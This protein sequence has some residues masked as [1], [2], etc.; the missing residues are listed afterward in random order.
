MLELAQSLV[1]NEDA[2][3]S[4]PE[5]KRPVFIYEW[6][7]FLNKV[8]VAAHKNDIREC[9]PKIVEQLLQQINYGPGPPIRTLIGKNLANLFSVGDTFPLFNTIN[10]CND[11]L[12]LKDDNMT[13]AKLATVV[14]IGALYERLGRL[15]GRSYEETVHLLLRTLKSTESQMRIEIMFTFEKIV[16]GLGSAGSTTQKEI[17]RAAKSSVCDRSMPVRSAAAM[18]LIALINQNNF[19]YTTDLDNN[20]LLGFRALDGSNYDVRCSVAKYLAALLA[21]SQ[22]PPLSNMNQSS[23]KAN[24]NTNSIRRAKTEDIL[25]YLAGG[26]LRGGVGFLK[27]NTTERIKGPTAVQREIRIGVTHTYVELARYLGTS[28]LEKNLSLFIDHVLELA[29]NP[30]S[31]TSHVDSVYS[32]KCITFILRSVIGSMLGEKAQFAAAKELCSIITRYITQQQLSVTAVTSTTTTSNSGIIDSTSTSLNSSTT[33]SNQSPS[34]TGSMVQSM[35]D[36]TVSLP[37]SEYT[38]HILICALQ[39]LSSLIQSLGTSASLLLHDSCN[40]LIDTL[41]L[42][43]LNSSHAVRL[44]SAWCLRSITTALPS[45]M[46][47]LIDRCLDKMY[48]LIKITTSANSDALSGYGLALQSLLGSVYLCP[49]GIPSQRGKLIFDF[50][51][52]LLRT[53]TTTSAIQQQALVPRIIIQR[54]HTGWHLLASCCTLGQ[55]F[56]KKFIPCLLLLWRNV[57]PRSAQDFEQEKLRGDI[58]TWQLSFNQRSGALCSMISFLLNCSAINVSQQQQQQTFTEA[59]NIVNDDLLKRMLNPVDNAAQMLSHLPNLVKQYGPQ[60][61]ASTAMFRLRLY[62]LLLLIPVKFFEQH[63]N[64]LLRELVAEF[65]LT[66]NSANTTTSLLRSVCHDN[67]SV[68]LGNWLQE[69]DYQ[70]IE[71]QL[72]PNSASGSG[73]LE[74]D[75][76]YLYRRVNPM[77]TNSLT[78]SSII[79]SNIINLLRTTT[80]ENINYSRPVELNVPGPLPLGVA[81]IDASI[82]LYGT[83]FVRVPNK[84]RLQM[85]QHFGDCIKQSKAQRQEAVQVNIF[86]AVLTALKCLAETKSSLDDEN[87]RKSACNLVLQTLSNNNP[88]LRCAAGEALGR[89]TQVVG[90]GRFV[91]EIAQFCFDRLKEYRDIPSRTGYSLALG[92]LHRYVGGI[93]AGQH[94]NLSVSILL[95]LAQDCSAPIVQVWSLHA[96]ALIADC[97]GQMFRGYVEPTLALILHLLLSVPSSQIDVFQCCGRL[98]GAL[99]IT[100]GPELQANTNYISILRSSCLTS[101][102]LLQMHIDPIVQAEAIQSLQQLHLFAPRHVNLSTLVPELIK[103]LKSRDL[104]LRRACVSC[105]RQLSQREAKEVSEHAKVFMKESSTTTG[106]LSEFHSLE[107]L[108][109]SMLDTETDSK[110]C[111]NVQDTLVCMLQALGENNLSHWLSLCKDVLAATT[112]TSNPTLSEP[113]QPSQSSSSQSTIRPSKNVTNGDN[114]DEDNF[115]LNED[116]SEDYT[117]TGG[118]ERL[119]TSKQNFRRAT[120]S[121]KWPTKVFASECIQKLIRCCETSTQLNASFHFDMIMAKERIKKHQNED[122]LILHINNLVTFSFMAST[123]TSDQLR[124]SG[125][126]L[127]KIIILKFSNVQEDQELPDHVIL[128]QYQAQVGA[129]LR[130]AFSADTPSHVTAKACDVCS[131][132]ISSGVAHDINDLRR[133]YQLLVSSL[134]K[135]TSTTKITQQQPSTTKNPNN[136]ETM[137]Y[138]ENALTIE[139][140]AVLKAWADVYNEAMKQ[141]H[142]TNKKQDSNLL[143]LVQPELNVLIHHWLA[144]LTDYAILT[145]PSEFGGQITDENNS[146]NSTMGGTFYSAESMDIARIIYKHNWSAIMQ[147]TTLWLCEHHY[148]LDILPANQKLLGFRQMYNSSKSIEQDD[149]N[150]QQ[151]NKTTNKIKFLPTTNNNNNSNSNKIRTFP[152]KKQDMF[153]MLLGCCIEALSISLTDQTM[154]TTDSIMNS[155]INLLNSKIACEQIN[156]AILIE[157]INVLHRLYFVRTDLATHL[158]I[159]QII[160]QIF[161]LVPMCSKIETTEDKLVPGE[162][163]LFA[164]LELIICVLLSY[165]PDVGGNLQLGPLFQM[166]TVKL[167]NNNNGNNYQYNELLISTLTLLTE[168]VALCS[169]DEALLSIIP[170]VLYLLLST[171]CVLITLKV[172]TNDHVFSIITQLLNNTCSTNMNSDDEQLTSILRC[173]VITI[174]N[175]RTD[176]KTKQIDDGGY[177]VQ[178]MTSLI[179]HSSSLD[180]LVPKNIFE[181]CLNFY[182]DAFTEE[183]YQSRLR[184]LKSLNILFQYS[185]LH[186]RCLFIQEFAPSLFIQLSKMQKTNLNEQQQQITI[187]ILKIIETL[188]TIVDSTH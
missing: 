140:L 18:C 96:L 104:S 124:L 147:A 83:M 137:I 32:R 164:S 25:N 15:V 107:E 65:T 66:D 127:L 44:S 26:F 33:S 155:V 121:A 176:L 158:R 101:S 9:Q 134:Q 37:S 10:K 31:S 68:L 7:C 43:L 145:L 118:E 133:V 48:K 151:G 70:T 89:L 106:T 102:T 117:D 79:S 146:N 39:E 135:F 12:K 34:T 173:A 16:N 165:Y 59:E 97:G 87:V 99:I 54:T 46:T 13:N 184:T 139:N 112:E 171:A 64:V 61:K 161:H 24:S 159:L 148:E 142:R 95:A 185:N 175:Y 131:T 114:D 72:Q 38:Q 2:L 179:T 141:E 168:I 74:H 181:L 115:D 90:D 73:A 178:C 183:M 53:T 172:E 126:S 157:L 84:H 160:D 45:L 152:D 143:M 128:E 149:N 111:S 28:W 11:I 138:S 42:V 17:Y 21:T 169:N 19:M 91:A 122:Y 76:T 188:F 81:V 85:L 129:A 30:R 5:K 50:A 62:E 55:Q 67:D 58:F 182:K 51:D 69:T 29:G 80:N 6:L 71:E 23:Q 186:I 153:A 56:I 27:S 8:L 92:C 20:V 47:P 170:I 150:G 49:L 120:S 125:L 103:A 75:E 163:F 174:I 166:K 123:S 177:F 162:S 100:I 1:L 109:F 60:L 36:S 180:L 22:N 3:N 105:L 132:W 35:N 63:F 94:L 52:D 110:L 78:N 187:E 41:L 167:L 154:E 93:G 130:P 119:H 77:N 57:F 116:D 108:L 144:A 14:V 88:I 82:L 40:G 113:E 86:T 156:K 4:L 98:L 136:S